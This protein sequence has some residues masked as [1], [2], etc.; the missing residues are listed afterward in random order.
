MWFQPWMKTALIVIGVIVLIAMVVFLYLL[1]AGADE[2]RRHERHVRR[3]DEKRGHEQ[4]AGPFDA[5]ANAVHD[6]PV[7]DED[8]ADG[9]QCGLD[10]IG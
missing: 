7:G 10:G 8:E 4:V 9:P 5:V 6:H 3:K 1:I 2:S